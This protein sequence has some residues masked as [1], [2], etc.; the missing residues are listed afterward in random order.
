LGEI[1]FWTILRISILIP[2]LWVA[3]GYVEFQFWWTIV[4]MSV[5]GVVIHPA[6]IHYR[7]F[8]EKNKEVISST[9]CSSCKHFDRSAVLCMKYDKHPGKNFLPCDGIDWTPKIPSQG[10]EDIY[11]Q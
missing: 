1:V 9:L 5:Y 8:E 7:L 3:Q 4:L 11:N 2:V 6:V 10:K